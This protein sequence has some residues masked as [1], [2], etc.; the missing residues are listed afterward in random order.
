M[1]S[2]MWHTFLTKNGTNNIIPDDVSIEDQVKMSFFFANSIY[3]CENTDQL[4]QCYH[5]TMGFP[6]TSTW[7][8]AIEAG[9][10][11]GWSGL[12]SKRVRCF[13]KIVEETEMGHMDQRRAGIRS[14]LVPPETMAEPDSMELV[15]QTLLIN[16]T[17]HV[18]MT[19]TDV[20]G[21]VYIHQT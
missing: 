12:T 21:K 20:E 19:T 3:E 13:I 4:I 5:T 2:N 6:A 11:K 16:C 7:Y 15:P 17:S 10:F 18:Y 1:Q 8:K 9:Y 14:T